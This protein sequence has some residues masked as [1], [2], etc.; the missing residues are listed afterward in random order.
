MGGMGASGRLPGGV[1]ADRRFARD[2]RRFSR[3]RRGGQGA[4]TG[5]MRMLAFALI[6]LMPQPALAGGG[7]LAILPV[8]ILDTSH[9]AR[10]QRD[11]HAR[12]LA[13]MTG[14]L[15]EEMPGT[16]VAPGAIARACPRESAECLM[17]MLRED[18]ADQGLFIVVQ[19]SSTLILQAFASLVDV[20]S[21]DLIL[22]KELNFR[23]DNDEAWRRAGRF[24]AAQLR[25]GR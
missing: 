14:V 19:K 21:G 25:E 23:G 16:P 24:M 3:L 9:E 2:T 13:L 18:G 15:A 20:E 1:R 10:D 5:R 11:D 6:L 12:R 7:G 8:K 22:H 17:A 4:Q